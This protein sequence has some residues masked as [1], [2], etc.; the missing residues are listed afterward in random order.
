MLILTL[1]FW[2]LRYY[3]WAFFQT[4]NGSPGAISEE[5]NQKENVI[6][7]VSHNIVDGMQ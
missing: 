3:R 6:N 4:V 1:N 2:D 7:D 5:V